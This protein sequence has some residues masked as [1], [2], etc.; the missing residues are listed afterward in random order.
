MAKLKRK[1]RHSIAG[2]EYKHYGD[3]GYESIA[4]DRQATGRLQRKTAA[5]KTRTE[6]TAQKEQQTYMPSSA[7]GPL[8]SAD[9]HKRE[10]RS[11]TQR[12]IME[13]RAYKRNYRK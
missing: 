11:V 4:K 9:W 7:S 10:G 8:N 2:T 1:G 12:S 13:H 5:I 6:T 3:K